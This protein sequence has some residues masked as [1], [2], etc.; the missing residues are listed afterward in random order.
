MRPKI[1]T[2][3]KVRKRT[4]RKFRFKIN[5]V[6]PWL[7]IALPILVVTFVLLGG[8]GLFWQRLTEGT[9]APAAPM[10]LHVRVPDRVFRG[11]LEGKKLIA[12]TFDDGPSAITTPQLLDVLKEKKVVATFFELG[13]NAA[14]NP[15]IVRRVVDQGN[16]LGSHTYSHQNL[17]MI[18]EIAVREDKNATD[19]AFREI[20]GTVPTLTR[21]PYGNFNQKVMEILDTPLILWSIDSRDWESK[22]PA[23]IKEIAIGQARDGAVILFHDIYSTTVEAIPEIIDRLREEGFEFVTV[24]E[25]ARFKGV[26]IKKGE[27]YRDF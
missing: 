23:K 11:N 9:I 3:P 12:L 17:V 27:Y 14:W 15:E 4:R 16:E 19:M 8:S 6:Y 22:D 26:E 1:K 7:K 24:S 10:S 5:K 25:L 2:E 13:R 21:P 18:S 20:I